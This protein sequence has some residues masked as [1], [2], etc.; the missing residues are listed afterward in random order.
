M[1][2]FNIK[3]KN[4]KLKS[5]RTGFTLIE[6]M[7]AVFILSIALTALLGLTS[8]SLFMAR[9]SRN[10]ITAN[11]LLQEASDYI[12]NKRDSVAFQQRFTK[13]GGWSN[14]LA[15]FGNSTSSSLCFSTNGCYFDVNTTINNSV[16]K[17]C[18]VLKPTFGK[19]K[20]PIFYYDSEAT[21]GSFYNYNSEIG[22]LSNF[23]RMIFFKKNPNNKNEIYITIKIEWLNGNLVQS[24]S[25]H[26]GLLNWLGSK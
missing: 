15:I 11:Y 7:V 1:I 22:S 13:N 6:T 12:R 3:N 24:K 2:F 23:K 20:C 19:L 10:E 8:K 5:T 25:L 14:F 21:N 17:L 16:I 18:N 26:L 9:Y 4:N